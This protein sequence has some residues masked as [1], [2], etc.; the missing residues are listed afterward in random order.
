MLGVVFVSPSVVR[1]TMLG[2]VFQWMTQRSLHNKSYIQGASFFNLF[3]L[4]YLWFFILEFKS[5]ICVLTLAE[6]PR[7]A[8][9]THLRISKQGLKYSRGAPEFPNQ[10]LRQIGYLEFKSFTWYKQTDYYFIYT[11]KFIAKKNYS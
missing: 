1:I 10:N 9:V 2:V 8:H 3:L 11:Y 6:V 5:I 4:F 7:V